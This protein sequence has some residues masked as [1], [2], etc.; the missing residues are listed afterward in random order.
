[1]PLTWRHIYIVAVASLGQLIGTAVATVAGVIIPMMNILAHPEL[2]TFMQGLIGCIDLIGIAI[3]S[4]IFGS[5][6]DKYGYLLF[7]RFC[8][9]LMLVASLVALFIPNVAVLTIALFFVGLGIGGEYSLDSGYVSELMPVKYRALMVGVTKTASALGNIIAAA[10]CFWVIMD[11]RNAADWHLLM[12]IVAAI[13]ALMLI[14]RIKFYESPKWLIDHGKIAEAEKAV[15][16]FLGKDVM[17]PVPDPQASPV[18]KVQNVDS[19]KHADT[20]NFFSFIIK[21]GKR[22]ILSGIPWACEGL[23]VYGIGV[24]LPIL[25][26]ALGLEHFT[27]G[28]PEILHVASSVKITLYISCIMLPGF[29]LGLWLINKKKSITAIQSVGFWLCA[30]TLVVLLLSYHF[31][32][33]K[34]ISIGAFMGFELF[35]NMGPHLITY[36]LPPKI[37]PVETRGE[38]VG[39]AA[40]IGKI[41]AVLG[42]FFIP[43]LLKAGGATLVLIVSIAVMAIG[44]IV[45]NIYGRLVQENEKETA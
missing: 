7:F 8:P 36:V 13:A 23:G 12:W 2:S 26:M 18:S 39:I 17:I 35:L 5:L 40:A 25:V 28:E 29:I 31:Q 38:G 24:F 30:A 37:Y 19:G 22:V 14:L 27:A 43:I 3:G 45:T 42:V 1:M 11:T 34:W 32:W 21:N 44:A 33:N 15:E 10:L 6:S 20:G 4:V 9:A 41:G 16:G